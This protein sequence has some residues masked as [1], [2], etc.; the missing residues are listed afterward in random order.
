MTRFLSIILPL[1]LCSGYA[2]NT[3]ADKP[4]EWNEAACQYYA[5][6]VN[7]G[8]LPSLTPAPKGYEVFHLEHYG[9]HGSR[10]LIGEDKYALAESILEK[11][12]KY[13]KLTPS[14]KHLLEDIRKV[15]K[16]S[17]HRQGELTPLG[18]RQHRQIAKRMTER[19]PEIFREGNYLNAN[20]TTVIRCILSMAN[21]MS[22]IEKLIPGMNVKMDA[23]FYTQDTLNFTHVDTIAEKLT[24]LAKPEIEKAFPKN[25]KD[26]TA[27]SSKVFNDN[28]WATDSIDV[29]KVFKCI[30]EIASNAQ[31]HDGLYDFKDLFTPEETYREMQ[32]RNAEWY[33]RSGNTKLTDNRPPYSQRHLLNNIIKSVDSTI[34]SKHIGANLRF[35]HESV[36]LPLIVL[37]GVEGS[38]YETTDLSTLSDN[39]RCFDYFP[40]ACNL[41]MVFYRPSNKK[42]YS[43][44]DVLVKFL[45][46]EKE[47]GI[48]VSTKQ[49]PYYKWADV[50]KF[51]KD[52]LDSFPI[53]FKE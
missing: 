32:E 35:G 28:G 4:V 17:F 14:G 33:L 9:R 27:F 2:L 11:A 8:N 34:N 24:E 21:E 7:D 6:P 1:A 39:W 52:K 43:V 46:N 18:H 48:P 40:M 10:W 5:Y 31:S 53:K 45:L 47:V 13:N 15:N 42:E 44:E 3:K 38:D 36:L 51:F 22:E 19:Y 25:T 29:L 49:Y 16:A 37:M 12:D 26:I 23:S 50:R 20:S 41:Q 30:Y